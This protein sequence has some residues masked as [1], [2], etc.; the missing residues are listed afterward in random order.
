MRPVAWILLAALPALFACE[1][2]P[3][4]IKVKVPQSSLH[5][6]RMDPV[7]PPFTKKGD[8]IKLRASA[9]YKDDSY[10]GPPK[11]V[12]WSSTDPSVATVGLDGL[13]T[14]VS[15]GD[16]QVRAMTVG[17]EKVLEAGLAVKAVIIEKIKIIPPEN[18]VDGHSIHMG[19][20]VKFSAKVLNDRDQVVPDAKV[21]WRN[22]GWAATVAVDGEVEG[23]AIGEGQLVAESGPAVDRFTLKVLDWRKE[24]RPKRRRRGR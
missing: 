8:T 11:R 15:S 1:K 14:I 5:S 7:L 20:I 18:L 17:G 3:A 13:V 6:V 10:M 21:K 19:D 16:T 9:F 24:N 12:K 2:Q 22:S 23:R 4:Y